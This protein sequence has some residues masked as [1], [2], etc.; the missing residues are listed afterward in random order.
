MRSEKD[1]SLPCAVALNSASHSSP[2]SQPARVNVTR[3]PDSTSSST[4]VTS[5]WKGR[6]DCGAMTFGLETNLDLEQGRRDLFAV[7]G[8]AVQQHRR[9][10]M[11]TAP[12]IDQPLERMLLTHRLCPPRVGPQGLVPEDEARGDG[13]IEGLDEI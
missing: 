10:A 1:S 11:E 12:R 6:P 4:I 13:A 9:V 5:V 7:E 8:G 3:V 2:S